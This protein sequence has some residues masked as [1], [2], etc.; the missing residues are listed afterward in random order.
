M[1][2]IV[3]EA[4]PTCAAFMKDN[5]F[6]RVIG[7]PVGSGKTT[8][9]IFELFRR[10]CEQ[11]PSEDGTRYTRFAIVRQTLKQLKDTVLK[12]ITDWLEGIA[13]YK[14]SESTIYITVGDIHSEWI[15][16]PLD[17]TEDQRRLLSMQLTGAWMSE[18]IEMD[19]GLIAPLSG[20]IGRY[21]AGKLGGASWSGIIADT[22]MPS[23]GSEW[24]KFMETLPSGWAKFIQPSGL[25]PEAENLPNL[26]QSAQT[27]RL[28]PTHPD[29]IARGRQ[30]Y[31]RFVEM[32]GED[33]DWVTRYVKAEY[34]DDPSGTAVFRHSFKQSFHVADELL[35]VT[36]HPLL[37]AQDFGRDPC[38]LI[39]QYDHKGRLLI[40]E[41]VMA[42][43]IGL[44]LHIERNLRPALSQARYLGRTLAVV[45]DPAGRSK[46]TIYEETSFD[47]LR[48]MGF[49]A[50]PAPTNDLD[51]RLRA[52]DNFL[53]AQRD[54]GAALLV[55]RE[56]CP[57]LI[58]ALGGGYRYAKTRAGVRKA[59]P[60]KNE[61]SHIAD[62][63]QYAC[64]VAQGGSSGMVG[65]IGRRLSGSPRGARVKV[66]AAAWT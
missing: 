15:L 8:A 2:N 14:V 41:E 63:L 9:C 34:G 39:C 18:C 17:N 47:A 11:E 56:R 1:A 55:D 23:M 54:G 3:F 16:I 10:A 24:H 22:N 42:E 25:S 38:S 58:R 5:S 26:N 45:G 35:P 28:P 66:S 33:S 53:L 49:I 44:Q 30:Y 59:T 65:L 50:F 32:Y 4:P 13:A 48:R 46:G 57:T 60:D 64:L 29:R 36:G 7:G 20:R 6:G 19:V 52:V 37:V 27:R 31:D 40:L 61:Y 62:C 51:P 12:D 21:P 43:D